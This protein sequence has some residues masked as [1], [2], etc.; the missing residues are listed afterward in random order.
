MKI[1]GKLKEIL[2]Y[3]LKI[4]YGIGNL[5]PQ[6]GIFNMLAQSGVLDR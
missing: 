6:V 4:W 5:N 2:W 3:Y 1:A